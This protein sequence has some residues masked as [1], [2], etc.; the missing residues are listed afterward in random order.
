VFCCHIKHASNIK[1]R[2]NIIRMFT[3]AG[4]S[5]FRHR[6]T[7]V[8]AAAVA[9]SVVHYYLSWANSSDDIG[10]RPHYYSQSDAASSDGSSST[11]DSTDVYEKEVLFENQCLKRQLY[12]PK[13]PYPAWDYNWDGNELPE[14]S[15][16]GNQKGLH[17]EVP[18]KTRHIILVRHGQYDETFSED[19]KR[20]L[21][22]LGRLQA[23]QT[24]KRL[25][26]LMEGSQ[27]FPK[28]QFRGPCPVVSIRVSDMARAK[29]TAQ[30]IASEMGVSVSPPDPDL[31]EALPA[32]MIP[33]RPDIR[34]A[35][36]EIDAHQGRIERAFQRYFYRDMRAPSS[37][38]EKDEA[39]TKSDDDDEEEKH[40]FEIIVCH[41][42]SYLSC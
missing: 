15:L 38:I 14:T 25:R 2:H 9:L 10:R 28:E 18:G 30:L 19:N 22:P 4:S 24:G 6:Q 20:I 13:V 5:F 32:P 27:A 12:Q 37:S 34:G 3:F 26:E 40:E 42:K 1:Q 29:E 21:T 36:E 39:E 7:Q 11:S 16:E 41:G 31:N 17:K 8:S 33:I 35:T 23:I